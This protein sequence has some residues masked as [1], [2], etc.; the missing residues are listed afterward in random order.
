[1]E[2]HGSTSAVSLTPRIADTAIRRLRSRN[3]ISV[4]TNRILR[5]SRRSRGVQFV[6]ET[7]SR[8]FGSKIGL[9][10]HKRH[11]HPIVANEQVEV[12]RVKKRWTAEERS[13]IVR[14]EAKAT[15]E[16]VR[17]I[18]QHLANIFKD[19]TLEAIKGLRKR[20]DYRQEVINIINM[21]RQ[22]QLVCASSS[23]NEVNDERAHSPIPNTILQNEN[24]VFPSTDILQ[25]IRHKINN[26]NSNI[27]N[28]SQ[29]LINIANKLLAG[30]SIS[31]DICL[32]L[33]SV[34]PNTGNNTTRHQRG[35]PQRNRQR[36]DRQQNREAPLSRRRQRRR[37]YAAIQAQ[38]KKNQSKTAALVLDGKKTFRIPTLDRMIEY[39]GPMF[40]ET[41]IQV[42]VGNKGN[43]GD[44]SSISAPV[45]V[46]D[47]KN[48]E[49]QMSS[50]PGVDGITPSQWRKIPPKL[51]ALF[52]SM[53]MAIGAFPTRLLLTRTIF[54]PKKDG[55]NEPADYRP[56]S[57]ASVV[58]RQLHKILAKRLR[59]F[60]LVGEHQRCM[61]DGCAENITI[62]AT[63]ISDARTNLKELH[64]AS[65]DLQKAYDSVSHHAILAALIEKGLPKWFITYIQ[66]LYQNSGTV[67]EVGKRKSDII[68]VTRGVRQGDPLSPLLFAFVVDK[69]MDAIPNTQGYIIMNQKIKVLAYAD[70]LIILASSKIGMQES[71][72]AA[73]VVA[74]SQ[75]LLFNADK[76]LTLSIVPS[77]RDKKYKVLTSPQFNLGTGSL[78]KQIGPT[79]QWRYLGV[80][81]SPVGVKKPGGILT[82]ELNR[83]SSAPLK[84][85]QKLKILRSYLIPRYYHGF[86]L[87]KCTSKIMKALDKQIRIAIRKWL[88]LP[89]DTPLGYFHASIKDGGL[90]IPSFETSIPG[91]MHERIMSMASSSLMAARAVI[92]HDYVL[93]RLRWTE[94]VLSNKDSTSMFSSE[95]RRTYWRRRL[96]QSI[97]GKELREC[98]RVPANNSWIDGG[99]VQ[100]PGK[101]YVQYNHVRINAL[102]SR[103]RNSRGR[104]ADRDLNCRAGCGVAETTAHIIQSCVRTHGGRIKR[105]DAVCRILSNALNNKGWNVVEN[106]H[107]HLPSGLMK[108]D[109][110][111]TKGEQAKIIDTQVVSGV[112]SLRE[113][114]Q[115]KVDK[116]N[117]TDLKTII[118][119]QSG[120]AIRNIE[121]SSC[122]LT[123]RG[124]WAS[125]S[126]ETLLAMGVTKGLL[127]NITTRVLQGS[128]TNWNRWNMMTTN[129]IS[130]RNM[131]RE[132]IG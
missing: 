9:G 16:G 104:R 129:I 111:A 132:G 46:E 52:Y 88:R 13:V 110:V 43:I 38:Y 15:L 82:V 44:W 81:F 128:H 6:C 109:I 117:N 106:P 57:V 84:P 45:S 69:I 33:D 51:R 107:Y 114:H 116:Y 77:G 85:Q 89:H 7:C 53:I 76:C 97:D 90:G 35:R 32:W 103:V 108:P 8:S 20:Q 25:D 61:D 99:S 73:E 42:P 123:W 102:P 78:L 100:I 54:V 91:L 48:S 63:A 93:K 60:G 21:M 94:R 71:L 39:W 95:G 130:H 113:H 26:L 3:I 118:S 14:S 10:V 66:N 36:R 98:S 17:F 1:M 31:E 18:N 59:N 101:D 92:N 41:S 23:R 30:E 124:I 112:G 126:A 83:I 119:S 122:T 96:Y 64:V 27:N 5:R 19:R 70:D 2:P 34:F 55:S 72:L 105:H 67:L 49:V 29:Q 22:Q 87:G 68:N 75:G 47:I 40:T 115:R 86:I 24:D 65:L 131:N 12:D 125:K 37:E 121:V 56:I 4:P 11:A 28:Q 120:V 79:D 50:A 127:G 74:R 80:N 62:L 58:V